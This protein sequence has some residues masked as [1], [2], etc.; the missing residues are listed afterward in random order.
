ML[1]EAERDVIL[2]GKTGWDGKIGWWVGWVEHPTGA[3]FFALNIDTPNGLD[4]LP[5][6][7]SITRTVLASIGALKQDAEQGSGGNG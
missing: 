7:E 3:V 4:D 6:R 5:K 1:I 2:R